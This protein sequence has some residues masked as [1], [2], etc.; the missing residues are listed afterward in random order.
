MTAA[1]GGRRLVLRVDAGPANGTGHLMRCLALVQAWTDLGGTAT[2]R[3]AA[4]P[5]GLVDRIRAEGVEVVRIEE[6]PASEADGAALLACLVE[7]P[8]AVA[9]VDG[10]HFR[11]PFLAALGDQGARVLLVDDM[12]ELATYPVGWILNQNAH[13]DLVAYPEGTTARLMLGLRWTMLRREFRVP[14]DDRPVPGVA[15]RLLVTFGGQDPT[16]MTLRSLRALR[17]VPGL[18]TRVGV[19]AANKDAGAIDYTH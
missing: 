4:A 14:P 8:Q 2:W 13:A 9:V 16:G 7:D 15:Q 17:E 6:P 5:D 11:E 18:E 12:A 10:Y 19:G 3:L 1:L